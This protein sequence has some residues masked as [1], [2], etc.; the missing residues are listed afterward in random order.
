MERV[1]LV[2]VG[3]ALHWLHFD[4]VMQVFTDTFTSDTSVAI[5]CHSVPQVA[6][7]HDYNSQMDALFHN[8]TPN[9]AFEVSLVRNCYQTLPFQRYYSSVQF[10]EFPQLTRTTLYHF[11]QFMRSTSYYNFFLET[12]ASRDD[13]VLQFVNFV[14]EREGKQTRIASCHLRSESDAQM[15]KSVKLDIVWPFFVYLLSNQRNA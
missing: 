12:S 11:F 9:Y 2:S 10:R 13:P 5:I 1:K 7:C 15:M 14:L 6:N 4:R 8:L 3:T